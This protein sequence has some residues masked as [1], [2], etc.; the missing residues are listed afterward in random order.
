MRRAVGANA[1][2]YAAIANRTTRLGPRP[3]LSDIQV[4]ETQP[5]HVAALGAAF[6]VSARGGRSGW[7]FESADGSTSVPIGHFAPAA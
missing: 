5:E 3:S 2:K 4:M 7:V 1:R 6:P